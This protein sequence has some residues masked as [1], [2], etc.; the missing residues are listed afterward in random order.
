MSEPFWLRARRENERLV[1]F[2]FPR[3]LF[4]LS[5]YLQQDFSNQENAARNSKKIYSFFNKKIE[6][7]RIEY[8]NE[9]SGERLNFKS[10]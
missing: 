5:K 2:E 7:L 4:S 10:I 1:I 8:S 9:I 6:Q 3:T